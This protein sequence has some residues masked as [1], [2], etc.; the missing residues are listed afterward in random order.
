VLID[1]ISDVICPWCFIGKRRLERALAARPEFD[2][3]IAWQPFQLNPDMPPEG[4]DRSAYLAAKFGSPAHAR[5]I[6]REVDRVGPEEGIAFAFDRIE[7]T[8]NTIDAHRLI[9]LAG[10]QGCQD[11]VVELLF[12]RYFE[13]GVDIGDT[14]RLVEIAVEAGIDCDVARADL[15]SGRGLEAVR[16]A[17]LQARK[18]GVAGVPCFVFDGRYAVSGAQAPEVFVRVLETARQA[19]SAD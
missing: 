13:E 4:M 7:R 11:R 3:Q 9:R 17:D 5:H 19:D 2:V 6:N 16:L 1:I 8:P 14:D 18:M 10:E 12:R 15:E